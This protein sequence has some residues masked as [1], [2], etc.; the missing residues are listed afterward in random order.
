MARVADQSERYVDMVDFL[1]NVLD[2][3]TEDLSSE[4]RN[5][6]SVGFKNLISSN[7]SAWRT[8]TAIEQNE[9]YAEYSEDC[10]NYKEKIEGELE[11][12]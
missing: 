6:L 1:E 12:Q 5:L 9:K 11:R 10:K 8:I 4:E 2:A 3:K 7:R